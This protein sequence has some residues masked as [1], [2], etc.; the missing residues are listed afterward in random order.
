MMQQIATQPSDIATPSL[1]L[2]VKV[3]PAGETDFTLVLQRA[4]DTL[5]A[6]ESAKMRADKIQG[7]QDVAH[8]NTNEGEQVNAQNSLTTKLEKDA[9]SEA[10][11]TESSQEAV[12]DSLAHK[13]DENKDT[14]ID[15]KPA[16]ISE[17]AQSETNVVDHEVS[18]E[19][20]TEDSFDFVNYVSL[21]KTLNESG[22][23]SHD[24]AVNQPIELTQEVDSDTSPE[25]HSQ[26][27]DK[28]PDAAP[29]IDI[30]LSNID[31]DVADFAIVHI[32]QEELSALIQA[33]IKQS[34]ATEA[35][36][37]T[38]AQLNEAINNLVSQYTD[39]S[40]IPSDE[41][42]SLDQ[43]LVS[44]LISPLPASAKEALSN[45]ENAAGT[46]GNKDLVADSTVEAN[47]KTTV[48][49]GA[50]TLVSETQMMSEKAADALIEEPQVKPELIKTQEQTQS[51]KIVID[52][53]KQDSTQSIQKLAEL[54]EARLAKA[55]DNLLARIEKSVIDVKQEVKGSEFI[56]ALQSGIKEYKEQLK[57]GREPGIDLKSLVFDAMQKNAGELPPATQTKLDTNIN[58]FASMLNLA[59]G[60]QVNNLQ[61]QGLLSPSE[62]IALEK[63]GQTFAQG[64]GES[65]KLNGQ[66]SQASALDKAVNIFKPDGQQQLVEKVRWMLNG[67]NTAA[68]IRLDPPEL[69][70]MQIKINMNGDAAAV[71]FTVQSVQAKEALD[72][73]TPRLRDMLQE[74]GIELGQS[75]VQQDAK[76]QSGGQEQGAKG[77]QGSGTQTVSASSV[78]DSMAE[79]QVLE[80]RVS[81]SALGGIDYYA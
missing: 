7:T 64:L 53:N 8:T 58:Q 80:Q 10:S 17:E 81:G 39:T 74:Q 14:T 57:Q 68:E 42:A 75:S 71:S 29:I 2:D 5:S 44:D 30:S 26:A 46:A 6:Y 4:K 9:T 67:R 50:Q 45:A 52:H 3:E 76:G 60:V 11:T 69:G 22:E 47:A 79:T 41:D 40:D 48:E 37:E 24:S 43:R 15:N 78:D 32:S 25:T 56:A 51:V 62:S 59:S 38:Q 54:D 1:P 49:L 13:T 66:A 21:V 16:A 34:A 65:A 12:N 31:E 73:A 70:A 35:S 19:F 20:E 77:S 33:Q 18:A 28:T 36:P 23:V 63:V 27:I 72:Q 61:A 55:L